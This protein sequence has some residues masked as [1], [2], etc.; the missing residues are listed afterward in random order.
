MT[1]QQPHIPTMK[2]VVETAELFGVSK[3]FIREM[4]KRGKIKAVRV[5]GRILINCD[6]FAE[7]LNN[8]TLD[9]E[10]DTEL[11]VVNGIRELK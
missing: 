5:A 10:T 9:N 3:Y 1:N 2:T 8:A 6:A 11:P 7:F 4:A